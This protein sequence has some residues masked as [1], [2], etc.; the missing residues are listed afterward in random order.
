MGGSKHAAFR[1]TSHQSVALVTQNAALPHTTTCKQ[2][3]SV[4]INTHYSV[5]AAF[6]SSSL[7]L[8]FS[9]SPNHYSKRPQISVSSQ[10][11]LQDIYKQRRQSGVL[12]SIPLFSFTLRL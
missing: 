12:Q 3:P 1:G 11:L 2:L 8:Y 5:T 4:Y 7:S 6:L 10:H 9:S